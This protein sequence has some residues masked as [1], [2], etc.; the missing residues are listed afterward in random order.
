MRIECWTCRKLYNRDEFVITVMDGGYYGGGKMYKAL[1][2]KCR[3]PTYLPQ[4]MY[5]AMEAAKVV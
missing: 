1:H 2:R 3:K 4:Q 5:R